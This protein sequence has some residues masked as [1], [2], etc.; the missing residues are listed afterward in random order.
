M[1]KSIWLGLAALMLLMCCMAGAGAEEYCECDE[2]GWTSE[3]YCNNANL[4]INCDLKLE[5]GKK[6]T[7]V[8]HYYACENPSK[9]KYCAA[10][11]DYRQANTND[12]VYGIVHE[13][14]EYRYINEEYCAWS[15]VICGDPWQ[16]GGDGHDVAECTG[17][18]MWCD[19]QIENPSSVSGHLYDCDRLCFYCGEEAP[20]G[21]D[22]AEHDYR[23]DGVCEDCGIRAESGTG[24]PEH[25]VRCS[26]SVCMD[27]GQK[28]ADLTA[29][30]VYVRHGK[31]TYA[32]EGHL[33]WQ[34]CRDCGEPD[35][36]RSIHSVERCTDT[37]C[38]WCGAEIDKSSAYGVDV[39]ENVVYTFYDEDRHQRT[40]KDCGETLD[41]LGYHDVGCDGKCKA[42]GAVIASE[43]NHDW[44]QAWDETHHWS[45][46]GICNEVL[47]E[48]R[49][50]Y[51]YCD[52]GNTCHGCDAPYSG[53]AIAHL[54]EMYVYVDQDGCQMKCMECGE[55]MGQKVPHTVWCYANTNSCSLCGAYCEN[56][57]LNHTQWLDTFES[58]ENHHWTTC[59]DCGVQME[60]MPHQ[61]YCA[62]ENTCGECGRKDLTEDMALHSPV[63][64]SYKAVDEKYHQQICK[65]CDGVVATRVHVDNDG[66]R[67]CN[68][69][70]GSMT[71]KE[72]L[73]TWSQERYCA[74]CGQFTA[75]KGSYDLKKHWGYCEVCG[76]E[77]EDD[78]QV[79]CENE[80][81]KIC[82]VCEGKGISYQDVEHS[83]ERVYQ[84][85][86]QNH[87]ESCSV[88]EEAM[89]EK[90]PHTFGEDGL[91]TVCGWQ[92]PVPGDAN[93]DRGVNARDALAVLRYANG[94]GN[95]IDKDACDVN[96]DGAVNGTDAQLILQYVA[97]RGVILK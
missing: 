5:G 31:Y 69:C 50:H 53:P 41:F 68:L 20:A 62:G 35:E 13:Y 93:G 11:Y 58:D 65:D 86:A 7:C 55:V 77:S 92:P 42:C 90:A 9:C 72:A 71:E 66:D 70:G 44:Q 76:K 89:E 3:A 17:R 36:Y 97:E 91:C 43:G 30:N 52:D 95:A 74:A 33:H 75:H 19:A 94:F 23:C 51:R 96:D 22:V 38:E 32:Y 26:T 56:P 81:E 49:E 73:G 2:N 10:P 78:H 21:A 67:V 40:C 46:C 4:C 80:A 8:Y 34:V 47:E 27:C 45:V 85:D 54:Y 16:Y 25:D 57:V 63:Y 1:K 28:I 37:V 12:F 64:Y 29:E 60:K 82:S 84:H 15:C 39:H 48:K 87:W 6:A 24:I 14:G 18:C 83:S 88:C 61:Y 59:Y 79:S